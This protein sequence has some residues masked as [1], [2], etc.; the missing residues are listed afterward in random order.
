MTHAP[1][2]WLAP[3]LLDPDKFGVGFKCTT[4]SDIFA[5]AC[6]CV[7]V[8]LTAAFARPSLT[9]VRVYTGEPPFPEL[10]DGIKVIRQVLAGMR[11]PRPDS[12]SRLAMSAEIWDVVQDC[13][14]ENYL[15]RPTCHWV[16]QSLR[17]IVSP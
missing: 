16:V 17:S 3:E 2:R 6:L 7:E 14:K 11:P 15:E 5:F 8:C 4:A 10:Q 1:I 13:W 9:F 12:T